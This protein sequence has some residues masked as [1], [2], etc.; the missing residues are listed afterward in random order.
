[1]PVYILHHRHDA[2]DCAASYAAWKGFPSP[3][4]RHTAL[5]SCVA[6]GH[7]IWWKVSAPGVAEATALLPRYV[8]ARTVVTEMREVV[9]P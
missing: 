9:I 5:S 7:E 8:A 1:V 2:A 4:R 6:G 3:L